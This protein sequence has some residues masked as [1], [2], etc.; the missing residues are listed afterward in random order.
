MGNSAGRGIDGR[1]PICTS[2]FVVVY[3]G[4][5]HIVISTQSFLECL[6]V[7]VTA[8]DEGFAGNIVFHGDFGGM[9]CEMVGTSRRRMN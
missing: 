7:V 4:R 8:L 2:F 5:G 6:G 3:D 1:G 9:I